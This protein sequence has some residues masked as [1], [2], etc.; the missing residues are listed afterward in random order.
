LPVK[1]NFRIFF[2]SLTISSPFLVFFKLWQLKCLCDYLQ[3]RL[4]RPNELSLAAV[5]RYLSDAQ[6]SSPTPSGH[7]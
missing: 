4:L 7:S 1:P 2:V 3:R 6:A 5:T